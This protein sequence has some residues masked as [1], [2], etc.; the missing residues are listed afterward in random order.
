MHKIIVSTVS[1]S[2][3]ALLFATA[4]YAQ[5]ASETTPATESPSADIVVTANK[6][7]AQRTLDAPISIQ[8]IGG[9]ALTSGG[10]K[11]FTD[12]ATK[13]PG[14]AVQDLGPGDRK[15]VIRG[16]DS[17]GASTTG[18]YFGEA[19]I[20]GSNANDGGGQQA[21]IRPYDLARVEVL[22][23]PQGTLYGASSMS[24]TIR[25]I[26]NSPNLEKFSGYVAA[27]GSH[28]Q[29][30][31]WNYN[32]N[33]MVNLPIV[34]DMLAVR[35]V[36][37]RVDDSG[38]I[39]QLRVGTTGP[40]KNINNNLTT[41][42]RAVV[43]FKPT[44]RLSIEGSFVRQFTD[45][46][47][48][49]RYTPP[50]V[51]SFAAPANPKY[52]P[53]IP[54]V[55]GCDLCNTDI[56]TSPWSDNLR[57]YGVKVDYDTGFGTLTFT[58]NQFDRH[59]TYWYDNTAILASFNFPIPSTTKEP[60][61]RS[62]N[63]MELRFASKFE[64]P[65]NFVVGGYRQ[66]EKS[67]LSVYVLSSNDLGQP[68]GPFNTTNAGDYFLSGGKGAAIFGRTDQRRVL[69]YAGFGEVTVKPTSTL[70]VV[71]GMRYF[72]ESLTGVQLQ[73]HPFF[74]YPA[75]GPAAPVV[76][77]EQTHHKLTYKIN[78]SNKFSSG[79][80]AYAT[81]STGFR[82]GGLNALSQPFEPIPAAFAPD[83][84]IN[85]EVGA[86]GRLFDGVF[87]YQVDGYFIH[88]NNMQIKETTADGSFNYIGN[89]GT[90][91][92]KGIEFELAARPVHALTLSVAGSYQNAKLVK[93]AT[94]AEKAANPTIG[95][96]GE[97]IPEVP[98]F[99]FSLGANYAIELSNDWT[100][101]PGADLAYMGKRDS[102]F[103]SDPF[104]VPLDAYALVNAQVEF[105]KGPWTAT[106]FLRNVGNK[107][108]QISVINETANPH[109]LITVRPRTIG[110]SFKRTF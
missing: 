1:T 95:L 58:D 101:T 72:T 64:G 91:N 4:A 65:V 27:E 22:R 14:L 12:V 30:G 71:G 44:E 21:D 62:V 96:A 36:G 98:K 11:E 43:L 82:S 87:D 110:V 99:Q 76:D 25:F 61:D 13:I 18:V 107:R 81:V 24:G 67:L 32:G 7:G 93:G 63:S 77:K 26:P 54:A 10:L 16:V 31:D 97:R 40:R 88:W 89:A 6:N 108:A 106:A 5:T 19:V 59:L 29:G 28:T 56:E 52:G 46:D 49:S 35:L 39:D 68:A 34:N 80:L 104:N 74:G 41:G 48:S 69:A 78:V 79:L 51:S 45:S 60:T 47:G 50:G 90:A 53:A 15:Y 17:S 20:S 86:K 66:L 3:I 42:G 37:W 23:G 92:I 100:M 70:T 33:A 94:P 109:A 102:Y 105:K 38:Y 73:T 84:L 75:T 85:Y 9:N 2:A 83:S 57:I 55:A 103:A 8:A